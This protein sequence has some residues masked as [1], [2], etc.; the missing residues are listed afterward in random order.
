MSCDNYKH[1]FQERDSFRNDYNI[2]AMLNK[3]KT[4]TYTEM[5]KL[6]E[7]CMK[8]ATIGT[9]VYIEQ[10]ANDYIISLNRNTK[11]NNV[12]ESTYATEAYKTLLN[13]IIELLQ[14][15]DNSVAIWIQEQM[16]EITE[17]VEQLE[18]QCKFNDE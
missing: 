11:M 5:Q 13:D 7:I 8:S 2:A 12:T 18:D 1:K 14:N 10:Q 17:I 15:R 6:L 16:L 3:N 4:Y 9:S